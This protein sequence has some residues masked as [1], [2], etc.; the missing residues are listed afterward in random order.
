MVARGGLNSLESKLY[1]MVQTK[2]EVIEVFSLPG[3][4]P[5]LERGYSRRRDELEAASRRHDSNGGRASSSCLSCGIGHM[6]FFCG[7]CPRDGISLA[8]DAG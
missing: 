2:E 5:R 3:D 1:S 8:P 7:T 4:E 6:K